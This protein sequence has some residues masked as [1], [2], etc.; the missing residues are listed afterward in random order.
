MPRRLEMGKINF[1]FGEGDLISFTEI[2][3]LIW[4]LKY[5]MTWYTEVQFRPMLTVWI[6]AL[7]FQTMIDS[8]TDVC[9]QVWLNEWGA[10]DRPGGSDYWTVK[11]SHST[12]YSA[13]NKEC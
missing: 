3:V 9:H 2:K 10:E 8:G 12:Q 11:L 13:R 1:G 6:K 5:D 7:K 4:Q